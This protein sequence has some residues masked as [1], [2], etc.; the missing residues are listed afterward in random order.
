MNQNDGRP[1]SYIDQV[2]EQTSA[3]VKRLLTEIETLTTAMARL[4]GERSFLESELNAREK[5]E[6]MLAQKL[7]EVRVESEAFL[8]QFS[9][10][11]QHNTNLANLYV[12]TYQLH[13]TLHRGTVLDAIQEIVVNLVGSEEFAILERDLESG[14]I[15][16][17]ASVGALGHAVAAD[18]TDVVRAF[19]TGAIHVADEPASD[20]VPACI[21]L[22]LDGDVIGAIAIRGLLPHKTSF[23]ALDRELFELL[24]SHASTAL[25]CSAMRERSSTSSGAVA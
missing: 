15:E 22:T 9:Q 23:E 13:G 25:F 3:Y 2:R 8:A 12:A 16:R 18:D 20:P 1:G 11:E 5:R 7:A 24:A 14:A 4:E 19:T 17:I 6:A 21:P 10:L